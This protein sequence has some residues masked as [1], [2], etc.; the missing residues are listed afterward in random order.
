[1][2]MIGE[3]ADLNGY[4]L[5]LRRCYVSGFRVKAYLAAFRA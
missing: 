3:V 4:Q 5:P 1:M 2:G